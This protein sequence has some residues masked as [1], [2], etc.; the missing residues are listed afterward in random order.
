MGLFEIKRPVI[1]SQKKGR[2]AWPKLTFYPIR[3][4]IIT[5]SGI[6]DII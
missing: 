6:N 2:I 3:I 4:I 1:R 5:F